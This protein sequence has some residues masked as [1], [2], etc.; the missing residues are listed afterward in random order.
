MS[1]VG[2]CGRSTAV[3][4]GKFTIKFHTLYLGLMAGVVLLATDNRPSRRCWP[5]RPYSFQEC[6]SYAA[7]AARR[8]G[9]SIRFSD[10]TISDL[11]SASRLGGAV[12]APFLNGR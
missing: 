10:T 1:W 8:A 5:H 9:R 6:L 4:H 7:F 3:S 11:W 2:A 12:A